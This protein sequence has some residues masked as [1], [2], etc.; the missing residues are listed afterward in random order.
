MSTET[1]LL[2]D[3]FYSGLWN[4][5]DEQIAAEIIHE[6]VIFQRSFEPERRGRDGFIAYLRSIHTAFGH[7]HCE[8]EAILATETQA[9]VWVAFS[10]EHRGTLLRVP[11]TG[12]LLRWVGSG[13]FVVGGGQIKEIRVLADIDSVK[14]QLGIAE[15]L[16]FG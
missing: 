8:I 4:Q 6:D 15:A 13:F 7:Y 3:R 1:K 12:Q 14:V 2:I 11:P 16:P 10:G 5:A 9:A